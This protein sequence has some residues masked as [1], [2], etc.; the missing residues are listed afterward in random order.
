MSCCCLPRLEYAVPMPSDRET[1]RLRAVSVFTGAAG[2]DSGLGQAGIDTV[3]M[4]ESWEPARRVLAEHYPTVPV[5]PDVKDFDPDGA[6]DVLAAGFPCVDLSHAG[7]RLGIFGPQSGLVEHV[8]RI[9]RTTSPA[10]IVLENVPNLLTLHKGRG[11]A[12]IVEQ[13]ELLGY[14]WAYRSVD[15]RTTGLPQRRRRVILVASLQQ[16]AA[17]T[18]L[19]EDEPQ[20]PIPAESTARRYSAQPSGFY[21]TEGRTGLGFVPGA[22]PTIKGGSR[23]GTPSAP[24][25]WFPEAETGR[26][27]ILPSIEDGEELQGLPRGWTSPARVDGERDPRWKLVGNAVTSGIGRWIGQRLVAAP[28]PDNRAAAAHARPGTW[29]KAASGGPGKPVTAST[30]SAWPVHNKAVT[31]GQVVDWR[32]AAPLSYRATRG[33]LSRIDEVDMQI[34]ARFYADLE[35]HLRATRPRAVVRPRPEGRSSA[36]GRKQTPVPTM[37]EV[38]RAR[39]SEAGIRYRLDARPERTL[40]HRY[41]LV[42]GR[43][44]VAVYI[45]DCF[46]GGCETHGSRGDD[47]QKRWATKIGRIRNQDD[48]A[49]ADLRGHGWVVCRVWTHDDPELAAATVVALAEAR[50]AGPTTAETSARHRGAEQIA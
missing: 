15:S 41:D 5:A 43:S 12:W 31:L 44:K 28:D 48:R 27:L 24:A 9:A 33:F 14:N 2:L 3:Q 34:D 4:C 6:Y 19:H 29:P 8:F 11:I 25:I 37:A 16:E 50:S 13:L 42:L 1:D 39:L 18:I 38:L 21:W 46:W 32:T 45:R 10:W 7:G 22:V 40:R 30:A 35:S 20:V 47:P 26:R 36:G 49:E 17:G 23:L